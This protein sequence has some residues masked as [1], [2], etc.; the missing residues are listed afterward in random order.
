ML[1]AVSNASRYDW[2]TWYGIIY[3]CIIPDEALK[4]FGKAIGEER[5]L[6]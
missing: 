1:A 3:G 6:F 2:S 4:L 5:Y